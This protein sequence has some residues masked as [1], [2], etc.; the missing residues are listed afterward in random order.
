[1]T[2]QHTETI[3]RLWDRFIRDQLATIP[4]EERRL[5]EQQFEDRFADLVQKGADTGS[6]ATTASS[7]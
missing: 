1:M 4:P 2:I 7:T 3:Q 6:T 5:Y